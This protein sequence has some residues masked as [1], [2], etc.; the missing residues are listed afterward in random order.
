L[1][2]RDFALVIDRGGIFAAWSG[3]RSSTQ[4]G[5]NLFLILMLAA[6]NQV[7]V[8]AVTIKVV[9][10]GC[11]KYEQRDDDV[12]SGETPG[13]PRP[14]Q[15]SR[16]VAKTVAGDMEFDLKIRRCC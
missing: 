16:D 4:C 6:A 10:L 11:L 15:Q 13:R 3:E 12:R 14:R 5:P 2:E 1:V 7:A 8:I 9:L